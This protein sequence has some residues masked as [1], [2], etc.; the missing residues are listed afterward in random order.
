VLG[1]SLGGHSVWHCLLSDPRIQTGVVIIGCPDFTRLM[2]QRAEKS[3]LKTWGP[4]FIGSTDFP[5][6][7]VQ[8]ISQYDPAGFLL[9]SNLKAPVSLTAGQSLDPSAAAQ[10]QILQVLNKNLAHKVI[11]NLSGGSDKL[12]PYACSAPFLSYLK[13]AISPEGWWKDNGLVLDD[14]IYEGV[15]HECTEKMLDDAVLFIGNVLAG[16]VGKRADRESR[17]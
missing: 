6:A 11:F 13:R 10:E 2:C 14:R 1:V 9:P 7:L 17:I 8:A 12:V 16:E 5:P 15:G 3:R 4:S